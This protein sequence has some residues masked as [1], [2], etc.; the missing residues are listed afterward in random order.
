[1]ETLK[2]AISD[3]MFDEAYEIVRHVEVVLNMQK[4]RVELLKDAEDS[5]FSYRAYREAHVEVAEQKGEES[6]FKRNHFSVWVETHHSW[7][8]DKFNE[9]GALHEALEHLRNDLGEG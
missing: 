4:Y 3:D 7:L 6:D 5:S 2:D 1:M 8:S 9:A